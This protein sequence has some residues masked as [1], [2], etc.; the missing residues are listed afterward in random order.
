MVRR[1]GRGHGDWRGVREAAPE[2]PAAGQETLLEALRS[3]IARQLA[4]LDDAGLTG[5][6]QSSSEVL[7]VPGDV[8][9]GKVIGQLVREIM[10]RGSRG[11]ALEPLPASS[12]M[13]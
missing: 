12:T 4:V 10:F 1:P 6:G 3:G 11:G 13:T 7:G 2:A 5:T 9:A 8:L